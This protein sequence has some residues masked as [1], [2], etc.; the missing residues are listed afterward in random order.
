MNLLPKGFLNKI[1]RALLSVIGAVVLWFVCT[2]IRNSVIDKKWED[3]AWATGP[4]VI[5]VF[6][7]GRMFYFLYHF[8]GSKTNV[9]VS[10]SEDG[11]LIAR[12]LKL[13]GFRIVRGSRSRGGLEAL[14]T[15]S[16]K[17][18]EGEP[19]AVTPDGP[20]GPGFRV[21]EGVIAL[22]RMTGCPLLPMTNGFKNKKVFNSWDGFVLPYPFTW[23]RLIF[24]EPML[25]PRDADLAFLEAKRLELEKTLNEITERADAPFE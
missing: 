3:Q 19:V 1:G 16:R 10:Q 20:R 7:H 11:Q 4:G 14:R 12:V 13:F 22:A 18:K 6:W 21:H 5:Y 23:G 8:R 9:L 17:L 24:A 15:T 25:V 2:T